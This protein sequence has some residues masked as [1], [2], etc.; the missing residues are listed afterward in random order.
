MKFT[1]KLVN[2]FDLNR[3]VATMLRKVKQD[4]VLC[5]SQDIET[6]DLTSDD[7]FVVVKIRFQSTVYKYSLQK[8]NFFTTF[9]L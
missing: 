7:S 3:N 1:I 4:E 6:T 5:Q 2:K 9:F 8:V